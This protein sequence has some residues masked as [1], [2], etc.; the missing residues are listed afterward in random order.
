MPSTDMPEAG[1]PHS[2]DNSQDSEPV[3]EGSLS[4]SSSSANS[5]PANIS[6]Q[7]QNPGN[8]EGVTQQLIFIA[9][10]TID[11]LQTLQIIPCAHSSSDTSSRNVAHEGSP[12]TDE[13]DC[14]LDLIIDSIAPPTLPTNDSYQR[15]SNTNRER[16]ANS[17]NPPSYT[18]IDTSF[19]N[20][21]NLSET[22]SSEQSDP[23]QYT[24]SLIHEKGSGSGDQ[25]SSI[26]NQSIE[27]S[28][29]STSS[30]PNHNLTLSEGDQP[31]LRIS[32][33]LIRASKRLLDFLAIVNSKPELY[34]E[35]FVSRAIYR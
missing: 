2:P 23:P 34:T 13:P 12:S 19:N 11:S 10:A 20:D 7:N 27:A 30:T 22:I 26:N 31:A 24:S 15:N 35:P 4:A 1:K 17:D 16:A 21:S 6:A 28:D 3:S 5:H 14:L 18:D 8:T 32:I 25:I 33:N 9:P 29:P